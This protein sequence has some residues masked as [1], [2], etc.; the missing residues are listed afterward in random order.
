[1]WFIGFLLRVDRSSLCEPW[2]ETR[3]TSW[4]TG[5]LVLPQQQPQVH[6]PSLRCWALFPSFRTSSEWCRDELYGAVSVAGMGSDNRLT[7]S[8]LSTVDVRP[9]AVPLPEHFRG[10]TLPVLPLPGLSL[11]LTLYPSNKFL[12]LK[13]DRIIFHYLQ[14]RAKWDKTASLL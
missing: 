1:M 10:E 4:Y 7:V 9:V 2:R 8:T 6:A 11:P 3:P 12:L 5:T 14:S 13:L